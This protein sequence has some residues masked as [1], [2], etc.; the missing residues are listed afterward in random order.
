MSS[1][2]TL[3]SPVNVGGLQLINRYLLGGNFL[4]HPTEIFALAGST[5][6]SPDFGTAAGSQ[7]VNPVSHFKLE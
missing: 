5:V 4:Y 1:H 2:D 7:C 3:L 6:F